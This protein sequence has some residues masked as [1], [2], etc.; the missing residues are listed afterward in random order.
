MKKNE[1]VGRVEAGEMLL[2]GTYSSA[3]GEKFSYRDKKSG[4]PRELA[5]IRSWVITPN[6][7][8]QV[9]TFVGE[10]ETHT[11]D[12]ANVKPLFKPGTPVVVFVKSMSEENGTTIVTGSTEVIENV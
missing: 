4:Q 12:A 11:F 1:I 10:A 6:G 5:L 3:K 7:P 2:V 9:K 8:V